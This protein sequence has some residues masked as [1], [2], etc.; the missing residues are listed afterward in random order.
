[1]FRFFLSKFN[2]PS[3]PPPGEEGGGG[4]GG[5]AGCAHYDLHHERVKLL[6][7]TL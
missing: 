5:G 1:M 6:S 7:W 4:G 3:T 2:L